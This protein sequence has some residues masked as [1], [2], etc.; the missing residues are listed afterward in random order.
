MKNVFILTVF[1]VCFFLQ[2]LCVYGA[3]SVEDS[4]MITQ[5]LE[6]ATKAKDIPA[7]M[8]LL[9]P[10]VDIVSIVT[11]N[12]A[13]SAKLNYQQYQR[14]LET[15][16]PLSREYAYQRSNETIDIAENGEKAVVKADINEKGFMNNE[17][18]RS[19]TNEILTLEEVDGK[20]L[21]TKINW[22]TELFDK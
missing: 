7:V 6:A 11:G 19:I 13:G 1:I 10:S 18:F 16:W 9:A 5:Q 20:I 22:Q 8:K 2:P 17:F 3:I 12:H 15:T 4:K 21:I 14:V